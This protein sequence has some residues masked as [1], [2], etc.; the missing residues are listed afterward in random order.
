MDAIYFKVKLRGIHRF[1]TPPRE[2]LTNESIFEVQ[3]CSKKRIKG[4]QRT[5]EMALHSYQSYVQLNVA[6]EERKGY[7]CIDL[8]QSIYRYFL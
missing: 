8:S 1:I 4:S 7:I 5:H 6:V 2:S 3:L